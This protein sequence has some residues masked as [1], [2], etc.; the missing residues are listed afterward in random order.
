MRCS[1]VPSRNMQNRATALSMV[2]NNPFAPLIG[3][4]DGG[5]GKLARP[6]SRRLLAVVLRSNAPFGVGSPMV[7]ALRNAILIS[8]QQLTV[9]KVQNRP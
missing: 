3:I 9:N 5:E 4:E 6:T 1:R 8:D 7:G 2:K